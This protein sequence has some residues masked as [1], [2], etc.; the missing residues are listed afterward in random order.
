MVGFHLFP[1][2]PGTWPYDFPGQVPSKLKAQKRTKKLELPVM[3]MKICLLAT[4]HQPRQ[5]PAQPVYKY[6]R[7]QL[8]FCRLQMSYTV[9][10]PAIQNS[11][12]TVAFNAFA[13]GDSDS[14][15][16]SVNQSSGGRMFCTYGRHGT[17]QTAVSLFIAHLCI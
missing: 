13:L 7:L 9:T 8:Y 14:E 12:I 5:L 16:I 10:A 3:I 15:L 17:S 6:H 4:D 2:S 1:Q 11:L